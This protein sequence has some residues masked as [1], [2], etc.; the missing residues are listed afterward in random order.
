MADELL[1]SQTKVLL[2]QRRKEILSRPRLLELLSDLLDFRLIII[3]APAGYGKT[4]LL[5]DFA[6][7]FDWPVCWLALDPL[8]NDTHRFLSHFVMSIKRQFPE[9]GDEAINILKTTPADQLNLEYLISV[10]TNDIY[11]KIT[12][13]FIVVLDDYHLLSSNGLIDTFLSEFIQRADDN[14]HIAITSRKLLTLP[15]LPLMVA[16]AQ[17][18]GLSI[19]ELVFQPDEIQKLYN[20]VFHR[21]IDLNE[22]SDIATASEGWITG[23]LLTSPMLRSGL[24]EPI[25]VA[26]ASGIGLYE[27]LA[28]QVLTQ[29]PENIRAFLLN[30]SILEE[31]NAEMCQKVIGN[32]L[33]QNEN[34]TRL[35]ESIFH[36]N[37]FVLP[38]DDEYKWL[39][40]HHLFRDFL[41]SMLESQRPQDAEKLRQH[42][43]KYFSERGDWERAFDIYQHLGDI[44]AI[45]SLI[46]QVGSVY[47]AKGK[48]TKL[49]N[50]LTL[51]PSS[52]ISNNPSLLSIQASV[53]FNQG[54]IQEGKNLLDKVIEKLGSVE[55]EGDYADN[56]IRRSAALR[57]LGDY[58]AA[59]KDAEK[60]ISLTSEKQGMEP[61][62]SEALRAKGTILF[63]TGFLKEGL[64]TLN[65]AIMICE[66]EKNDEDIARILVEVGA[67]YERLGQFIEAERSYERSLAYWQSAGDSIWVATILNNLGVLQ[68][69]NGEFINSFYNLEKSMKYSQLTGN[70][71]MEGYALASIGDLYKD[72]DALE[73]ASD[74]YQ[75]ALEIAQQ[76]ED[77]YLIFYLKISG[78]QIGNK[79]ESNI[80][81]RNTNTH[82]N[83]NGKKKRFS[84]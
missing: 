52:V 41:R 46:E 53:I 72:L 65:Q 36:N 54:H 74:A 78:C 35:M 19:E 11:E 16:R 43:A 33:N 70:Q 24:G 13:H 27:Y 18:G 77:Q 6:H 55:N 38:V 64:E 34:W 80:K 81:S 82:C 76:I 15:D 58:D 1:I 9:F 73:E 2:P 60:A 23:L 26:R 56:L 4:S 57:I 63:Q 3:A 67:I 21:N 75:K 62:Y 22:A 84:I 66:H 68:H 7:Q 25:K 44:Q 39:R 42:L 10:L 49:S 47:I 37:L 51:L 14:C 59:A 45:A 69:S 5:I 31:F 30:S 17:V 8:D 61:L 50:L 12:E 29:Q 40:Y 79:P 48:I 20:Q 32:A 28:Q 71:R 83:C